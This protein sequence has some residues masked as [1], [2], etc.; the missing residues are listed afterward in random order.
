V[1]VDSGRPYFQNRSLDVL[2]CQSANENNRFIGKFYQ[3]TVFR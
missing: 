1:R 3:A 2:Q